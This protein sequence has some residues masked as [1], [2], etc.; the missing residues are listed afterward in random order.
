M[1]ARGATIKPAWRLPS[2]MTVVVDIACPECGETDAVR[3]IGIGRYE[4]QEC[5]TRFD[6]TEVSP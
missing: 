2:G 1:T 5:E 3:K 6:D 4:C